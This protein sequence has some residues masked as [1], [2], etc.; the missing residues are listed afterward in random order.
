M[1]VR[2]TNL[3]WSQREQSTL[4][5]CEKSL[6]VCRLITDYGLEA[7]AGLRALVSG[8]NRNDERKL[9]I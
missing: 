1:S 7:L 9:I 4:H 3:N 6:K 5:P 8:G 2:K